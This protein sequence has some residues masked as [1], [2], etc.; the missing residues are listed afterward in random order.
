MIEL[1]QMGGMAMW[2][3]LVFGL[4]TVAAAGHYAATPDTVRARQMLALGALTLLA[5]LA[6][7][8]MGFIVTLTSMGAVAPEQRFIA[9]I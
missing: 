9:L 2:V 8:A 7:T 6:G 4:G 5:G 1:F 3:I